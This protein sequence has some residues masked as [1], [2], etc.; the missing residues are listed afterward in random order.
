M[1]YHIVSKYCCHRC[2]PRLEH[3][4]ELGL[5]IKPEPEARYPKHPNPYPFSP[6]PV[7]QIIPTGN[8]I[9]YPN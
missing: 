1:A 4:M 2:L 3:R 9:E 7:T 6:M 8:K 5:G